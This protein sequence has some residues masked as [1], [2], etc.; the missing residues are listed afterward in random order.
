MRCSSSRITSSLSMP[1]CL[2]TSARQRIVRIALS[3]W[4]SVKWPRS[5]YMM[6]MSKSLARSL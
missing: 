4:A 1:M 5:E 3:V 2:L 6:F